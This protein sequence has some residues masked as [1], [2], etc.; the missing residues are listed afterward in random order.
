[1]PPKNCPVKAHTI[2]VLSTVKE[3]DRALHRMQSAMRSCPSCPEKEDC[4]VIMEFRE[5]L[6][7]ALHEI[8]EEWG[9]E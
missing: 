8:Y 4:P 7:I 6:S 5:H 1:M 2:L 9:L 3:L